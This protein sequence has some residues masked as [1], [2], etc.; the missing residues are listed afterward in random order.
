MHISNR[1]LGFRQIKLNFEL[2]KDSMRQLN[3]NYMSSK[4]EERVLNGMK[5]A[6]SS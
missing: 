3:N 2:N 4:I 5:Y 1:E 6:C